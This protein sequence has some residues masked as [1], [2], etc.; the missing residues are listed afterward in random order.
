MFYQPEKIVRFLFKNLSSMILQR[1][2]SHFNFFLYIDIRSN[3]RIKEKIFHC[4]SQMF[5]PST[6]MDWDTDEG[7]IGLV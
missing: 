5:V 1:R 7:E 2:H 3:K 4:L 6:F